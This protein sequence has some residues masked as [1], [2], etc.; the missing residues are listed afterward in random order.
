MKKTLMQQDMLMRTMIVLLTGLF[1]ICG[2]A[3]AAYDITIETVKPHVYILAA[4]S[5]EGRGVGEVGEAKA[6][7]YIEN[8]FKSAGLA[9]K[10]DN[11]GFR[12]SF[13]FVK[14]IEYGKK[15]KLFVNGSEMKMGVDYQ[16]MRQSASMTFDFSNPVFVGYGITVPAAE[17]TYDDYQGKDV[18]G[19]AVIV[20]RHAPPKESNPHVDLEKYSSITDKINFA[21]EHKATGILFVTPSDHDDTLPSFGPVT[22]QPKDLPI[23]YL[24]RTAL[25]NMKLAIDSPLIA[26]ALGQ[27]ELIK[28]RDT[29]FNVVGYLEGQSDTTIIIGAHF[30]HLGWGGEGSRYLDTI[31]AIHNGADDNASGTAGV[32]ELAR[33]YA[34][35]KESLHYSLLFCAFSGE[36]SGLLGSSHYAKHMTIDSSKVRM[37]INMDMIG[38][39]SGNDTGLAVFG[40]GTAAEFKPYFDSLT[41]NDMK[42]AFREPGTGPSDHTAFYNRNIPV[43]HFFTGAH[44]DY[45]KPSDDADLI[46]YDGMVKVLNIVK[47]VIDTFEKP[48]AVLAFQKTVDPMEGKR[49]SSFSVTLG[50][51]PDYTADVKGLKVDGVSSGRPAEKAGILSGDVIIKMGDL[52]IGDIGD[53]MSALGKFRKGD[54]TNVFVVRAADT[55]SLQV[56][57]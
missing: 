21:I 1:T 52:I 35:R 23:L 13:D 17:G 44:N 51:M 11:G 49:M 50:I 32:I 45:H 10:G 20:L 40:T 36:E 19:K 47:G 26:T 2:G 22:V 30:D 9:P 54:S 27:T 56:K 38:R 41:S 48:S 18:A 14:R 5:L 57:F 46:D 12:Q 55:L 3:F 33:Y 8:M 4:D 53:Y 29:G 39:L 25:E 43:L 34:S 15:N 37:M 42:L 7:L 16:P 31:P 24:R 6:G 28:T